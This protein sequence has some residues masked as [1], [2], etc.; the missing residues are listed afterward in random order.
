AGKDVKAPNVFERVK[1]EF[2]A[3]FHNNKQGHQHHKETH[4][5]RDDIDV[6]T[7]AGDVK[8]PNVFERAKEEIEAIVGVIHGRKEPGD[9]DL[10]LSGETSLMKSFSLTMFAPTLAEKNNVKAPTIGVK[11]KEE[12]KAVGNKPHH[13]HETHGTSYDFDENTPISEFKGPNVFERAKEEIEALV[14][15][16]HHKKDSGNDVS[17]ARKKDRFPISIGK[18]LEKI[19]SPRGH[20][21]D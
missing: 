1:E 13:H 12:S 19:C 15:T 21:R 10:Q 3:V 7:S 5:L 16:I 17:S 8:A 14:Q 6:N 2:E 9:S 18:G 20:N 4:G 11:A